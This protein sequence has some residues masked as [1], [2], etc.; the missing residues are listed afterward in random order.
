VTR[1]VLN[2]DLVADLIPPER[3]AVVRRAMIFGAHVLAHPDYWNTKLGLASANPNMTASILLPRGLMALALAGHPEADGWLRGAEEELGREIDNWVS[4]GGAW[5]EAPGYQPATLDAL[6]LLAQALRTTTG[7]DVFATPK[8]R[9]TLDYFGFLLTA[10]DRRFAPKGADPPMVLPSIGDTFAGYTTPFNGWMATATAARDPAFSARQ[11][12]YWK[13]QASMYGNGG[14]AKG[15]VPA[16]TD[17]DLPATPPPETGRAFPGFGAILR[18][19]WTDPRQS[20]VALRTGPNEHHYELGEH[21]SIVYYAKGAPLCLDWGNLAPERGEP[22]YHNA[23]S[24]EAAAPARIPLSGAIVSA[25]SLPGFVEAA[26]GTTRGS[27]TQ[28]SLRHLLLVESADPMGANYLVIRDH[29][30]GGQPGQRFYYNLFCLMRPPVVEEGEA[31]FPGQMGVDLD[32]FVLSPAHAPITTDHWGWKQ[33]IA[34]WREFSEEQYGI[35]VTKEGS[36]D[37]FFTVL[38]PRAS[39][40][41]PPRARAIAGGVAARVDHVE[42]SDVVLVSPGRPAA[43]REGGAALSG[44]IA[45]ARRYRRGGI[46]LAVIA[47][48]ASAELGGWGLRSAGP[49]ALEAAGATA[50]GV[51]SGEAH[52]IAVTLPP[53]LRAPVVRVDD[54]VVEARRAGPTVTIAM[55]AGAHR[56]AISPR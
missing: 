5:V 35:R 19:S 49:A 15:F 38:Y 56:F 48:D 23:V 41:R 25:T 51:S 45:L 47:G 32:T 26:H 10:P 9:D 6:F 18:S 44:E 1:L 29:T 16:L 31:H 11:Q 4:P 2:W 33:Q 22:W 43:V 53:A 39:A 54:A 46:R 50:S 40:E 14:R 28:E 52:E 55:P 21:G 30:T 17:P 3:A 7:R 27:G 20:Y 34:T 36:R 13:Q 37:D 24:F 8:L 42:G 12:F